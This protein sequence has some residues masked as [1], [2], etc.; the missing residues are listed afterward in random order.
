MIKKLAL[1]SLLLGCVLS[2]QAH[3]QELE[4][5][6]AKLLDVIR[7]LSELSGSNIVASNR[8]AEI[9]VNVYLKDI[10]VKAAIES[11]CRINNLWY[12]FDSGAN[13]YRLMTKQEYLEDLT[14]AQ[15]FYTKVLFIRHLNMPD[16]EKSLQALYGDRINQKAEQSNVNNLSV[17]QIASLDTNSFSNV[18][19]ANSL[20]SISD[21]AEQIYLTILKQQKQLIVRSSNEEVV[22]EI[23]QLIKKIDVQTAQVML[24]MQIIETSIDDSFSSVFDY[25]LT[26]SGLTGNSELP[27]KVGGGTDL[28][29]TFVYQYLNDKLLANIELLKQD[30]RSQ[31]ISSPRL[32]AVNDQPATLFVGEEFVMIQEYEVSSQTNELTGVVSNTVVPKITT[33]TIGNTINITP[34]VNHDNSVTLDIQQESS[35]IRQS[36]SNIPVIVQNEVLSLPMDVVAATSLKGNVIGFHGQPIAIGGLVRTSTKTIQRK[37]PVLGSI[38]LLGVMFRS[39][40][41]QELKTEL[42]LIITPYIIRGENKEYAITKDQ[43]K[44]NQKNYQFKCL[45]LC[46]K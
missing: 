12:R 43:L 44:F 39:T 3:I 27:I 22:L 42:M 38:P 40:I 4:F 2:V 45:E 10:S 8:A 14:V 19:T 37:I 20:N 33:K 35:S 41:Q 30:N 17:D 31:V 32:L 5:K 46:K 23:E 29:G 1:L 6:Q 24:E 13:S 18:V 11:I 26:D 36:G 25:S 21:T 16:L 15:T 34:H 7:V 28:G 9:K